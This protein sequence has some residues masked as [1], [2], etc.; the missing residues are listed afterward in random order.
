MVQAR[1][2]DRPERYVV[3]ANMRADAKNAKFQ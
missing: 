3:T 1:H 2:R